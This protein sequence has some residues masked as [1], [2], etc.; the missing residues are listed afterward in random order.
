ER[1]HVW[2][3]NRWD[4]IDYLLGGLVGQKGLRKDVFHNSNKNVLD[5]M[6]GACSIRKERKT[7]AT[8]H[9]PALL[10][11]WTSRTSPNLPWKKKMRAITSQNTR[12]NI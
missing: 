6:I 12:Q 8:R 10:K 4:I 7:L 5:V 11:K 2:I 9:V 3:R 1:Q